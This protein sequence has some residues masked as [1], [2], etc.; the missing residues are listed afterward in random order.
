MKC[1]CLRLSQRLTYSVF[2]FLHVV[3]HLNAHTP[4]SLSAG[5]GASMSTV[6]EGISGWLG[7]THL[8]HLGMLLLFEVCLILVRPQTLPYI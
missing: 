1:H 6:R 7:E 3:D 5:L 8:P 4:P 2:D